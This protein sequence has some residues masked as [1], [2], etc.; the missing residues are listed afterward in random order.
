MSMRENVAKAL[1]KAAGSDRSYG[2]CLH[3]QGQPCSM[4]EEFLREADAAIVAISK[5]KGGWKEIRDRSLR[6]LGV[7]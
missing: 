7:P 5:T 3:C 2:R 4:W 1:C 6:N